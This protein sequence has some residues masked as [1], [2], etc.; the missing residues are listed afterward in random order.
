M[1][2]EALDC[3]CITRD[4]VPIDGGNINSVPI[5]GNMRQFARNSLIK[6]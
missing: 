5:I 3:N 2:L 4:A 6:I 1:S